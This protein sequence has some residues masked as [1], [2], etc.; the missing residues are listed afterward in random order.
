MFAIPASMLTWGFEAEAERMARRARKKSQQAD[1]YFSGSSSDNTTDDEY[2]RLIAGDDDDGDEADEEP[3]MRRVREA[4]E[5]AD[6]NHDGTLTLKETK[7]LV[8]AGGFQGGAGGPDFERRL[9]SLEE[10][11]ASNT[12]KLDK[13]LEILSTKE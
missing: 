1:S 7:N 9:S 11:V 8:M 4:F 12:K 6:I 2:F 5:T 10:V 13:I 3:W